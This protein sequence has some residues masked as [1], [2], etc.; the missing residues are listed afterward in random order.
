MPVQKGG[1][2]AIDKLK[3]MGGDKSF[4]THKA[5]ATEYGS[6]GELPPG[7]T[8]VATLVEAKLDTFKSGNNKDAPYL[9]IRGVIVEC[10]NQMYIG[11]QA[12]KQVPLCPDPTTWAE[13]RT[14]D[15]RIAEGLNEM[16]KLGV[17][18]AKMTLDDWEAALLGLKQGAPAFKFHTWAATNQQTKQPG[19]TRTDIDGVVENYKP[20]EGAL[21]VDDQS[22]DDQGVVGDAPQDD[23]W[24]ALGQAADNGDEEAGKQIVEAG[25]GAGLTQEELNAF[26]TWAEAAA[27][28]GAASEGVGNNGGDN[29]VATDETAAEVWK[30]KV[31]DIYQYKPKGARAAIDCEVTAV[32]KE[33]VNL[34]RL[35]KNEVIKG[36]KWG[37]NPDNIGGQEV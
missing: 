2:S 30:P 32:F 5:D 21:L 4:N 24:T 10:S 20:G 3:K 9:Q 26:G 1:S 31:T 15:D 37:N 33:T 35:D 18:T 12:M 29:G 16:R 28:V 22:G 7:L 23:P 36:V 25:L 6:G 19:R 8:G 13:P 11:N 27:A 17:E 14:L 34:K